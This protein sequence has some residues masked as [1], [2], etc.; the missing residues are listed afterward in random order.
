MLKDEVLTILIKQSGFLSGEEMSRKLGVS[1]MAV[2]NAVKALRA[3]GYRID[4]VTNRG[5][6]LTAGA[7]K[8]NAG[9]VYAH[10]P[11]TRCETVRCFET[12]DSTN[13]YLKREALSGAP[14]GLCA[15]A[16]E[17]TAGRGRS[18]R[19]FLSAPDCGVYLSML[20]RPYC[21]P[22]RAMTLTAHAA[23]A[24]CRAI[25]RTAGIQPGIKW[26]ND[27]VLNGRKL[28]GILTEITLEGETGLIDSVVIGIGVNANN[29][30]E[31]FPPEL[32]EVAGSICSE[33]GKPVDRAALAAA[34]VLSLDEMAADW[35]KDPHAYLNAYR[36]RCVTTGKEV[37]VLRG[38]SERNAF[39]LGVTESFALLVRYDDGTEERLSSGEV[40]VRGLLG[41]Q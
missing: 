27:I 19:S 38:D 12:L 13:S 8:L 36:E 23:V 5:Y 6:C 28:C 22:E 14:S 1:R 30:A 31:S 35:Q 26:T 37:R 21:T 15:I 33:S 29:A 20:L 10:L 34:M 11:E 40:S 16:N 25:E 39:A 32:R 17:Q 7:D 4:S 24:V 18:G 2:S 3:D 41:Y 9:A